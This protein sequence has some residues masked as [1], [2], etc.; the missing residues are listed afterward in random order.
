MCC[1]AVVHARVRHFVSSSVALSN[2]RGARVAEVRG[3]AR[4]RFQI[5]R[6][7][8]ALKKVCRRRN[9]TTLKIKSLHSTDCE[10][11]LSTLARTTLEYG[12]YA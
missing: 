3:S 7:E 2:S 12:Y 5:P 10:L 11:F 8:R 9:I 6:R 1:V 4:S